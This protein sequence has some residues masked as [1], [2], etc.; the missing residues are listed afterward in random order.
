MVWLI[1]AILVALPLPY[2]RMILHVAT[3]RT[4]MVLAEA[5]GDALVSAMA[6]QAGVI[7]LAVSVIVP[8]AAALWLWTRHPAVIQGIGVVVLAGLFLSQLI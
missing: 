8:V 7:A 2:D 1:A 3:S 6:L 4:A 5:G